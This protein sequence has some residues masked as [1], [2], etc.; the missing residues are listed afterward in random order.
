[1]PHVASAASLA[2][3][4]FAVL[5]G[6]AQDAGVPQA[7]CRCATC[8]AAWRDPA[9]R[10]LVTCLGL[11]DPAAGAIWLVDATPDLRE[12]LAW[13]E[14][15][16]PGCHLAGILL[17]HAHMGHYLGLAHLGRE[18]MNARGL[19]LFVTARMARF[20]RANGPWSQLVELGNV[21]LH[22]VR[23]GEPLALAPDLVAEAVTVPHR[24]EYSDTV[25]WRVRGPARTLFYCPDI[26]DWD[27]WDQDLG[28]V[29]SAVEVAL[30]DGTFFGSEELPGRDR[31]A[32]PHPL[33][34]DTV[35]RLAGSGRGVLFTHFNHTNPL[36]LPGPER[37][38]LEA[39]GHAVGE[40]GRTWVLGAP[41][42]A[43][44]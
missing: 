19:P 12:Q 43:K 16:A 31:A 28:A 9:R 22:E 36:L 17:T 35:A 42:A 7:G 21:V 10:A 32:V 4:A 39:Q 15:L 25:A 5:L 3:P 38:W 8:A 30:L 26:D 29:V 18:A 41:A 44:P 11:A 34:E 13:L 27:G 2:A 20:L 37:T 24:S 33:V 23:P 6:I 40:A 14:T 1:M